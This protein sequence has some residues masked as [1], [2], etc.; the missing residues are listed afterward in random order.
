MNNPKTTYYDILRNHPSTS[1]ALRELLKSRFWKPI[2]AFVTSD[3]QFC[4]YLHNYKTGYDLRICN[5]SICDL[6]ISFYQPGSTPKLLGNRRSH[7]LQPTSIALPE[8]K[9]RFGYNGNIPEGII[10]HDEAEVII[11]S[12][13]DN[14]LVVDY[15][16]AYDDYMNDD[17]IIIHQYVS[18][19]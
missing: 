7:N 3:G 10:D 15:I 14:Q 6:Q 8:Y 1:K 12:Y 17:T 5:D 13:Q 11:S 9:I 2:M 18:N 19:S 4:T 16:L